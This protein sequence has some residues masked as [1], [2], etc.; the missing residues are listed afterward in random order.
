MEPLDASHLQIEALLQGKAINALSDELIPP[1]LAMLNEL[2]AAPYSEEELLRI[3]HI[4]LN[5]LQLTIGEPGFFDERIAK[6]Q[7]LIQDNPGHPWKVTELASQVEMSVRHFRHL[8][9]RQAGLP[10]RRYIKWIRVIWAAKQLLSGVSVGDAAITSGFADA[11][12]LTR[13]FRDI[14]GT[15][16]TSVS[17]TLEVYFPE[18][19]FPFKKEE[20]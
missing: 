12:H 19:S 4:F 17:K 5:T 1:F 16:P 20:R 6:A 14:T 11:G 10:P 8:F 18:D 13:S 2:H 15:L 3:K 9:V 7:K